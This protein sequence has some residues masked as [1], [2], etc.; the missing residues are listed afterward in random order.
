MKNNPEDTNLYPSVNINGKE[1]NK[2]S[3]KRFENLKGKTLE[4][5]YYLAA[6]QGTHGVREIQ[7]E[8]GYSSPSVAAYHLD[9]LYNYEL[10]KK[11]ESGKYFIEGDP[12]KLG[13]LKDR[14]LFLGYYIP[15][16]ILYS[17]HGILSIIAV[18]VL[19][20]VNAAIIVW[21]WYFTLSNLVFLGFILRDAIVSSKLQIG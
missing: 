9:G 14:I 13:E 11:T 6:N 7:K 1:M 17:Y 21:V 2:K 15:R 18:F 8:M 4:L 20:S 3:Q 16:I 19:W 12:E 10:V 5:Y